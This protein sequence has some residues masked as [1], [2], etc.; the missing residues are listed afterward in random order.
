MK[1]LNLLMLIS[2]TSLSLLV[3]IIGTILLTE[4]T[5]AQDQSSCFMTDTAGTVIDLSDLCDSRSNRLSKRENTE[6]LNNIV[7]TTINRSALVDRP[8]R[9]TVYFVGNGSVPFNLG[10]S[11]NSYYTGTQS[12]YV[13]RYQ[14]SQILGNREAARNDLLSS[15]QVLSRNNS[16]RSLTSISGGRF[17]VPARTPFIIYRYQK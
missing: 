9:E 1:K 13:R 5:I 10:T 7:N 16:T 15:G 12:V 8:A 4:V 2:K 11:A 6:D 14:T 17:V 3:S